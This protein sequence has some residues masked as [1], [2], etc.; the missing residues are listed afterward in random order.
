MIKLE[1]PWIA[2]L[3][4]MWVAYDR[5]AARKELGYPSVSPMFARALGMAAET[6][7]ADGYSNA[8][9]KAMYQAIDW[10]RQNHPLHAEAINAAFRPWAG[11]DAAVN[12]QLV[13][14]AA[15]MLAKYIDA[16]LD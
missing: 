6:D 3:L 5:S 10:L 15:T 12:A 2:D 9:V 16:L 7:D 8:E 4:G 13:Q 1:P 14:E 11:G